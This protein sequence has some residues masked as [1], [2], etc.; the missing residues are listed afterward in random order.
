[1]Q[2]LLSVLVVMVM[3]FGC[4]TSVFAAPEDETEVTE[5][6]TEQQTEVTV[7]STE[8]IVATEE[9]STSTEEV[10]EADVT[11]E[12]TE[13]VTEAPSTEA[14]EATTT[15]QEYIFVEETTAPPVYDYTEA[16]ETEIEEQPSSETNPW[17]FEIPTEGTI[18]AEQSKADY[19]T[20][21]VM[22]SAVGGGLLILLIMFI[23]KRKS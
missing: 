19:F 16:Q 17:D 6:I 13:M 12:T 11:E 20:G 8:E 2:V 18:E 5:Q 23:G 9:P 4:M 15:T 7:E 14:T 21:T 10:T 1:M 22:W 3:M